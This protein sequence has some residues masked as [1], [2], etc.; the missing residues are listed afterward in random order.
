MAKFGY[1]NT[2]NVSTGH[3]SFELNC[4]YHPRMTYKEELK[5]RFKSKSVNKLSAKLK[6]LVIVCREKFY[7]TQELE[8]QAHT[9]GVKLWSYI[10]D[11]KI[12]LN[13]KY[14]KTKRNCKW[15][16][17]FFGLFQIVHYIGK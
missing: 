10:P 2:N 16:T 3:M 5:L 12:W 14:I 6:K 4:S 1:N 17:K 7:H 11:K 13:S 15:E 8:K 9:K